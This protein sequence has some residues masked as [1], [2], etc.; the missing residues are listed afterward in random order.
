VS[1][2]EQFADMIATLAVASF[3]WISSVVGPD[4][5]TGSLAPAHASTPGQDQL[6]AVMRWAQ[7]DDEPPIEQAGEDT[8]EDLETLD[9]TAPEDVETLDEAASPAEESDP[10]ADVELLDQGPSNATQDDVELLDQAPPLTTV[11]EETAPSTV[12]TE[13]VTSDTAP[14]APN[15][16]VVPEGFGTGSVH[17]ATGAAGFPV[18]LE[19]CHVGAVTGRA[20][21]GIDCGDGGGSSFVGHAPSFEDFPFVLEESFPFGQESVFANRQEG[22]IEVYVESLIS[23]AHGAPLHADTSAPEIQTSGASSVEFEQRARG[24]K[25]RV[26]SE[27]GRAVRGQESRR[28]RTADGT[29][30]ESRGGGDQSSAEAKQKTKK[31][32]KESNRD[33]SAADAEKK[34]KSSKHGKNQDG[35]KAKKSRTSK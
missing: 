26:E 4:D 21:V 29:L 30:S 19:D 24:R 16:L 3:A 32:G 1:N 23:A 8:E 17:V 20:Y 11:V 33:A 13:P 10:A 34:A 28:E 31:R 5:P 12:A 25:P 35:K 6:G 18:G 9:E 7:Q 22:P 15:E 27:N 2:W 14:A